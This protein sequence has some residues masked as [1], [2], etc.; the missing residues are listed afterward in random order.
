MT[1]PLVRT[2]QWGMSSGARGNPGQWSIIWLF[3][4]VKGVLWLRDHG[5]SYS[6]GFAIRVA[7]NIPMVRYIVGCPWG[8]H[9]IGVETGQYDGLLSDLVFTSPTTFQAVVNREE[10]IWRLEVEIVEE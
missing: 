2:R 3:R 8:K 4:L 5:V 9:E 6:Q 10:M 1:A 7:G